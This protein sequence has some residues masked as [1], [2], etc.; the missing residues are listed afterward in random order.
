MEIHLQTS[1]YATPCGQPYCPAPSQRVDC[2][3]GSRS[4]LEES[5]VP[6]DQS[7]VLHSCHPIHAGRCG[8][9]YH[10]VTDGG[11]FVVTFY[12]HNKKPWRRYIL[13]IASKATQMTSFDLLV[14]WVIVVKH[15][16][17]LKAVK[18]TCL[19]TKKQSIANSTSC[20]SL[21]ISL[22]TLT[23][24][25][26]KHLPFC[27]TVFPFILRTDQPQITSVAL[28]SSIVTSDP[29]TPPALTIALKSEV[30]GKSIFR[31]APLP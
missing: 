22:G 16:L 6:L 5:N 21:M 17:V 18:N 15:I 3:G 10:H 28:A 19:L 11:K 2:C 31:I 13:Y 20:W 12:H 27:Q 26:I 4:F 14:R 9:A 23:I 24:L 7:T 8:E 29:G 30:K 25:C 1:Q